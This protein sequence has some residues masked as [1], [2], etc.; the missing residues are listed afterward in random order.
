M[1]VFRKLESLGIKDKYSRDYVYRL[2]RYIYNEDYL[3]FKEKD[4]EKAIFYVRN[5]VRKIFAQWKQLNKTKEKLKEK[6]SN[7]SYPISGIAF[8]YLYA[9]CEDHFADDDNSRNRF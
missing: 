3:H 6:F 2:L 5:S 9:M 8:H 4:R 1:G 7:S